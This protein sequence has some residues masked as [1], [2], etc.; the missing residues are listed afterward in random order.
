MMKAFEWNSTFYFC[1]EFSVTVECLDLMT[2]WFNKT[3]HH[4]SCIDLV[5]SQIRRLDDETTLTCFWHWSKVTNAS[6]VND[7]KTFQGFQRK[8]RN[9]YDLALKA[10]ET[11]SNPLSQLHFYFDH[12]AST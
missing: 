3:S 9:R 12:D 2:K 11:T 7:R 5:C 4:C 1:F 10:I 8:L 6:N